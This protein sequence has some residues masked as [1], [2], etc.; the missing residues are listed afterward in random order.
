MYI[1]ADVEWVVN[2][3]NKNSP[4]QPEAVRVDDN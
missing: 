1:I 2:H 4:T 3:S